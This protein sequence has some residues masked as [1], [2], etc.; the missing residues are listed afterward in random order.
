MANPIMSKNVLD[1]SYLIA[2][3]SSQAFNPRVLALA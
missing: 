3:S 1:T 2:P